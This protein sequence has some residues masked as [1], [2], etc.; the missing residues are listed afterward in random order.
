MSHKPR[1]RSP[2]ESHDSLIDLLLAEREKIAQQYGR[3]AANNA[4]SKRIEIVKDLDRRGM[5]QRSLE[6]N[7]KYAVTIHPDSWAYK[8]MADGILV[9]WGALTGKSGTPYDPDNR[10]G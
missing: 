6:L 9:E 4:L 5:S 2:S 8:Y 3:E 1:V 7:W 10:F